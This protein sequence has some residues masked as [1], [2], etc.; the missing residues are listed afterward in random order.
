MSQPHE[1]QP[2]RMIEN[3]VQK[4]APLKTSRYTQLLDKRASQSC[5]KF[6]VPHCWHN[7]S[8]STQAHTLSCQCNISVLLSWSHLLLFAFVFCTIAAFSTHV[9][10]L[11][12]LCV[13]MHTPDLQYWYDVQMC[14]LCQIYGVDRGQHHLLALQLLWASRLHNKI[15]L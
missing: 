15:T 9:I 2:R 7:I 12:A 8:W 11:H 10:K 6:M 4:S 13:L 5:R 14:T 3:V 1:F